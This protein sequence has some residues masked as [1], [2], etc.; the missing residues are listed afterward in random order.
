MEESAVGS[1]VGQGGELST[2]FAAFTNFHRRTW[3]AHLGLHPS[4]MCRV[5]FDFGVA[6][7][8]R[9]VDRESIQRSLRGVIGKDLERING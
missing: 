9:E 2:R 7:F 4:G 8:V 3:T 5:D 1:I 6:Q